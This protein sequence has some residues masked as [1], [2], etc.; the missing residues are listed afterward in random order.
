MN[1]KGTT[2]SKTKK[3]EVTAALQNLGC[4]WS[5][6]LAPCLQLPAKKRHWFHRLA[7]GAE[8]CVLGAHEEVSL[9]VSRAMLRFSLEVKLSQDLSH[10]TV[11]VVTPPTPPPRLTN[12][13]PSVARYVFGGRHVIIH[14]IWCP[15]RRERRKKHI[16]V[17]T[18]CPRQR[19][20]RRQW[21]RRRQQRPRIICAPKQSRL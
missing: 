12:D 13:P 17:P 9:L 11:N 1:D 16:R 8:P 2:E 3:W 18:V 15:L 6:L 21:Q 7:K 19:R 14:R 20:R 4:W 5:I 10:A